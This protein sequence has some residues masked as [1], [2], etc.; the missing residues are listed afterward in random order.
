M[1]LCQGDSVSRGDY[2]CKP[3]TPIAGLFA[4]SSEAI[5]LY[6]VRA[7]WGRR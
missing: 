2:P 3:C 5:G 6:S 7:R 4:S 1:K